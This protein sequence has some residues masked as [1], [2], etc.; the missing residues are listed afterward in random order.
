MVEKI[1]KLSV[2]KKMFGYAVVF[3]NLTLILDTFL[4]IEDISILEMFTLRPRDNLFVI[5]LSVLV[6]SPR[7]NEK[8]FARR[9]RNLNVGVYSH[10]P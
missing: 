9:P 7:K 10:F 2:W 5:N 8:E 1:I 3:K 4:S 6:L